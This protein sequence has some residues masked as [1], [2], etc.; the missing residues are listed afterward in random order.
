MEELREREKG[1]LGLRLC[2]C[3]FLVEHYIGVVFVIK[4]ACC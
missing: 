2:D 4:T 3:R 1:R